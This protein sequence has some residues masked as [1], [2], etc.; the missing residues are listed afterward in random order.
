METELTE[1]LDT[2]KRLAKQLCEHLVLMGAANAVITAEI[3]E[4]CFEVTVQH[5]PKPQ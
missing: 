3:G 2:G 1:E 5:K 4:E